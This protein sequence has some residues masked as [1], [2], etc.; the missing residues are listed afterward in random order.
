MFFVTSKRPGYV[1]FAMTPSER[2]ALGITEDQQ[3][4]HVLERTGGEWR[5][6][7]EFAMAEHSHT[8]LMTRLANVDEPATVD[9]LVRLALGA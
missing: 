9:E 3:R 4:V 7:R 6:H 8:H 5:V 1:L 2:A